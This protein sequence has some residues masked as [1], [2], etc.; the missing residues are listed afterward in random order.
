MLRY[1][2]FLVSYGPFG[3]QRPTK[4]LGLG[5]KVWGFLGMRV[6]A[7]QF[8]GLTL[9]SSRERDLARSGSRTISE[10]LRLITAEGEASAASHR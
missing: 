3:F 8:L 10:P 5:I 6:W 1:F 7:L 2:P 9:K 4:V